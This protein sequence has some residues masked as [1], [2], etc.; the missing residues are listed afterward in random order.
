MRWFFRRPTVVQV[1]LT[2]ATRGSGA[3]LYK[4]PFMKRHGMA[5]AATLVGVVAIGGAMAFM[6]R[7]PTAPA[8]ASVATAE[9][10]AAPASEGN[11]LKPL[12]VRR[13]E[14]FAALLTRAG[15]SQAD[16]RAAAASIAA[17]YDTRRMAAGQEV[18]VYFKR[19]EEKLNGFFIADP[20]VYVTATRGPDGAFK[21][22]A[23]ER[24]LTFEIA[25]INGAVGDNLYQTATEAGATDREVDMLADVCGF[26]LDMQ[27]DVTPR[28]R[29]ELVF[30]RIYDEAGKTVKTG[31]LL[32]V[33]LDTAKGPRRFY[34]FKAP[35]ERVAQWYDS[36]GRSARRMLMKTPVNGARLSSNF[37]ARRHPILGFTRMHRGVDFAA[38]SGAPIVAA[39]DGVVQRA[40][41]NGSYGNY[42]RIQHGQNYATAYGH[43]SRIAVRAGARVRQGQ[44]IGYVGSTGA[45]TGPHL[46]YEVLLAGQ[47]INPMGIDFATGRNL[48]YRELAALQ[49]DVERVDTMRANLWRGETRTPV[50]GP[51]REPIG[52]YAREEEGAAPQRG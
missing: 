24:E 19:G 15:A 27:R 34:A 23:V 9:V 40:G 51:I 46:H 14:G 8:V 5:I 42:V 33:A 36:Q 43:M 32:F 30:E 31:E 18:A 1:P 7:T 25:R 11:V 21:G 41:V 38:A 37:G 12:T 13:R 16:A 35:G 6:A 49:R 4:P 26:E 45:S 50:R 22:A 48:T 2:Q 10:A 17:L 20:S 3:R 44:V 39:G 29:F 28:D 52:R 47:Q